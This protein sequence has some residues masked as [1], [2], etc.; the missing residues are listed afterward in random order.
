MKK[1]RDVLRLTFELGMSRRK[2]SA[3]TG[4]GR[5]AVTD[6]VQRMGAAGLTWPL[7][8]GLDDADLERRLYPPGVA[9]KGQPGSNPTGPSST[10]R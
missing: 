7:P 1:I 8:V 3:A 2:V 5:T 4:I 6:Y 9:A 10:P